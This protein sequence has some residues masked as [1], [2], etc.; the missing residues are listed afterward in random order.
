[1]ASFHKTASSTPSTSL[2]SPKQPPQEKQTLQMGF[3]S[4]KPEGR[5]TG[6]RSLQSQRAR[7]VRR[8]QPSAYKPN[9]LQQ[10]KNPSRRSHWCTGYKS[11]PPKSVSW[12]WATKRTWS[13]L[14]IP[15]NVQISN[16]IPQNTSHWNPSG[17]GNQ[18]PNSP[19]HSRRD[20]QVTCWIHTRPHH[21]GPYKC[22]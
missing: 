10:G 15:L 18:Q 9:V 2:S 3:G 5:L 11:E 8:G 21:Q 6:T 12:T 20:P 4:M 1:M 13:C 7:F 17:R 22:I 19:K 16:Q 14:E